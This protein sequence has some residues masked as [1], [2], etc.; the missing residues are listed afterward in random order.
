MDTIFNYNNKFWQAMT[1][2]V[3][4]CFVS[5]LW[6]IWCVPIFTVGASTTA[7]YYTVNKVICHNRS[8]VFTEFWGSFKRNFKQATVIWLILLVL[9]IVF[10]ADAMI[11]RAF[12]EVD[13]PAG[14]FF[15]VFYALL[16]LEV[17]WGIYIF[18]NLAR[19]ENTTKQILKNAIL[20]AVAHFPRSLLILLLFVITMLLLRLLPF[21]ILFLPACLTWLYNKILEKIFRKYMSEEAIKEEDE[22]NREYYG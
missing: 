1:K 20:M 5:I 19:F 10:G 16:L 6:F 7:M 4:V 22:K 8:Y 17:V 11:M 12:Y 18:G 13:N 15:G 9:G 3:S 21:G 14:K 2:I